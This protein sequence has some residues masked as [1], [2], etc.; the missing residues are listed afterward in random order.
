MLQ[1]KRSYW[2]PPT[3][4]IENTRREHILHSN[5]QIESRRGRGRSRRWCKHRA[6]EGDLEEGHLD[7]SAVLEEHT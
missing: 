3:L 2:P 5:H 6:G 1:L 4:I 7:L